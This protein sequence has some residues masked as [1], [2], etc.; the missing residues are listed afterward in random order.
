[1]DDKITNR[2]E[3][4]TVDP[5]AQTTTSCRTAGLPR[6]WTTSS[7]YL[8]GEMITKLKWWRKDEYSLA[9]GGWNWLWH[10]WS[11][12]IQMFFTHKSIEDG[13]EKMLK[14]A[15]EWSLAQ[16]PCNGW[17]LQRQQT[18]RRHEIWAQTE[19]SVDSTFGTWARM[20]LEPESKHS[21]AYNQS[22][23]LMYMDHTYFRS[24]RNKYLQSNAYEKLAFR[25]ALYD[26]T[27]ISLRWCKTCIL[28]TLS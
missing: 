3:H 23:C 4:S 1:M 26:T 2:E 25:Q 27:I 6:P 15:L 22:P 12:T 9:F 17:H 19:P 14:M 18:N 11:Q 8:I 28:C 5:V 10:M 7:A 13:R 21:I 16:M 24:S 20:S